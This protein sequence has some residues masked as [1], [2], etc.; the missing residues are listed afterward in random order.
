MDVDAVRRAFPILKQ[1]VHGKPLVYLDSAATAQ[2][3]Q[4]VIEATTTFYA[5]ENANIHRGV[6]FLSMQATRRYDEARARIAQAIGAAEAREVIFVRGATEAINLVAQC[7]LR[8]R[9]QEGDEILLTEME[10]HANIIP[11]QLVAS[12]TGA[13][14]KAIPIT[15]EGV[16]DLEAAANMMNERTRML[17]FAHISNVL[18]TINPAKE[19]VSLAKAQNIP[20]LVDGAQAIP[21][22]PVDVQSLGADFYTFSG[23]KVYGPDGIGVLYGH[24]NILNAMPP[25]QGG[26]DMIERVQFEGST[27][28][29]IPERFEAGTPNIS[30]AISLAVAFDYLESLGWE[31]IQAHETTLL[32]TAL[33]RLAEVP[34][35]TLYGPTENRAS[36]VSF[37][38]KDVHPHDIGTFLDGDGIA[39]RVGHHCAQP[40]MDRLGVAATTRASFALYNTIEEI[41]KLVAALLKVQRFFG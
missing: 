32:H 14:V 18:G 30:A 39:I 25:Y 41:D 21:H 27:F 20:V 6:H 5:N 36:V 4:P 12:A 38:I 11:W 17:A 31:S 3:P 10:H 28:R 13:T 9:L 1:E 7:F 26:G 22:G 33:E 2:K 34:G 29:D 19:L 35:I 16:V 37:A 23:H 40:L 8:S 15:D 24:T